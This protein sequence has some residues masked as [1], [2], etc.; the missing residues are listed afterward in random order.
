MPSYAFFQK[1]I[2]PLEE[3]KIGIMT[4]AFHYG[5]AVFEGIRGNWN[6]EQKQTYIFRMKE[7]YERLVNGCK[8]LKINLALLHRRAVPENR[9][10]GGEMRFPGRRLYPAG[11]LYQ[12]AGAGRAAA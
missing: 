2:I 6:A 3:A 11:G 10:T 7:H 4:H 1:K 12:L 5:T 8:V 9:G